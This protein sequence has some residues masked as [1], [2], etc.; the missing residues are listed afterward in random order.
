MNLHIDWLKGIFLK[1]SN[2]LKKF[3][4]DPD[5]D[6]SGINRSG[7]TTLI[8]R[9]ASEILPENPTLLFL[10]S[11]HKLE[12]DIRPDTGNQESPDDWL[13]KEAG[14]KPP[15]LENAML[16]F[17]LN[18]RTISKREHPDFREARYQTSRISGKIYIR[19]IPCDSK[20]HDGNLNPGTEWM[21][22]GAWMNEKVIL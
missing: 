5:S 3:G 8:I 2:M 14:Q 4:S 7:F 16:M 9:D 13:D 15:G 10:K 11:G 6:G 19:S 1:C 18:N 20:D 21:S 22:T 12:S 17:R